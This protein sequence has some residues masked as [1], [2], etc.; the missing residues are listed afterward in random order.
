MNLI[1]KIIYALQ[2][3]ITRPK[4]YGLFHIECIFISIVLLIYLIKRKEKNKEI[5]LKKI[6]YI[7]GF[8]ALVLEILKQIVWSFNYDSVLNTVTW[9]YQWYAFPFQLCTTP[10][11][12]SIICIYLKKGKTRNSLLSYMAFTTIL[13]SLATA[14]YPESCYVK[15]LL[16]DIHTMYLHFGSLIVSLYLLITHEID[17]K[18]KNLLSGYNV[19]IIFALVAE[20]M[21]II[22]YNSSILGDETFNMFY[23]SPYFISILPIYDIIQSNTPFIVFILI[24]LLTIFIGSLIIWLVTKY[25]DNII[26]KLKNKEYKKL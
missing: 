15:M 11:F 21:N 16:I 4:S 19:F 6:L 7:Y 12:A 23:I 8:G 9:D 17:T 5:S 25:I 13:G 24:Y 10:I 2:Y 26:T 3:E 1:E 14:I 20:I 22:M 18:L